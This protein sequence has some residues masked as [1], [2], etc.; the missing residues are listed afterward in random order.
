MAK[1][2]LYTVV[3]TSSLI[4]GWAT[5]LADAEALQNQDFR[6]RVIVELVNPADERRQEPVTLKVFSPSSEEQ[7]L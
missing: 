7:D 2:N 3:D 1:S 6:N 4:G 5:S